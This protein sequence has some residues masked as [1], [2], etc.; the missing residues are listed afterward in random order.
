VPE[1]P[2]AT[3]PSDTVPRQPGREAP[4]LDWITLKGILITALVIAGT[5]AIVVLIR[6]QTAKEARRRAPR[7]N[8]DI[9]A[10]MRLARVRPGTRPGH[11]PEENEPDALAS[12]TEYPV[13]M[14]DISLYGTKINLKGARLDDQASI[15]L[16]LNDRWH[17]ARVVWSNAR[18]AGVEFS[19][20]LEL[21][22]LTTLLARTRRGSGR[23]GARRK[24]KTAPAGAV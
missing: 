19:T 9:E 1:V 12:P 18:F 15:D 23:R 24:D 7:F 10:R 13:T 6:R 5:V 16:L 3:S 14:E 22:A 8:C 11:K 2:A 21:D 20:P 4:R 17:G